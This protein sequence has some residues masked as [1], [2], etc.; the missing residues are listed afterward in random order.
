MTYFFDDEMNPA[1]GGE[2]ETGAP[3]APASDD[4]VE[5]APAADEPAEGGE[6]TPAA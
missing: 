4:G 1:A 2:G 3:D 5:A 6:E